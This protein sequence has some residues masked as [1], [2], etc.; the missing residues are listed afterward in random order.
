L[1]AAG[2]E[3]ARAAGATLRSLREGPALVISSPRR[4]AL[5]TAE[6]AGLHVDEITED[7][8][9]WDYGDYEGVT[10]EQIRETVPGWTVW[11]HPVPGGESAEDISRRADKVLE[12]IRE[13]L[14][15]T[16]VI[17]VG[18]GHFGRVLVARW[19]DERASFGVRFAL[20]PASITVLGDERGTPQ[21]QHLNI[22][23]K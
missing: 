20:D 13:A 18:H 22:T 1:T 19:I 6:L 10:T 14:A 23:P 8:T 17:L 11:S 5:H 3:Q 9:E 16:D 2:E 12:R 4:R 21:I 15:E 7:V